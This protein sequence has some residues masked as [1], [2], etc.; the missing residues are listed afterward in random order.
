MYKRGIDTRLSM[1]RAEERRRIDTGARR[2]LTD[3][4][5]TEPARASDGE[6]ERYPHVERAAET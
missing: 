1:K 2:L 6:K 3:T 4:V 5:Q